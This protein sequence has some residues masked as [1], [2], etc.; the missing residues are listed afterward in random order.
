MT[1]AEGLRAELRDA[2]EESHRDHVALREEM[3]EGFRT[4]RDEAREDRKHIHGR[5]NELASQQATTATRVDDIRGDYV[6]TGALQAA[7]S[8]HTLRTLGGA[9]AILVPAVISLAMHFLR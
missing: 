6:T 3:R 1:D 7:I 8:V 9:L 5:V 4:L 2:R